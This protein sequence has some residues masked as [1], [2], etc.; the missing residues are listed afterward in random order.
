MHVRFVLIVCVVALLS[1][2]VAFAEGPGGLPVDSEALM[3]AYHRPAGPLEQALRSTAASARSEGLE[4]DQAGSTSQPAT[5]FSTPDRK[6]HLLAALVGAGMT[7][8]G[9]VLVTTD[10]NKL[11]ELCAK[12]QVGIAVATS[13]GVIAGWGVW[14]L[15]KD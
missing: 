12:Q 2:A 13:G 11:F 6:R 9:L 10:C 5:A 1:P 7:V 4:R 3:A 8:T 14:N 15:L